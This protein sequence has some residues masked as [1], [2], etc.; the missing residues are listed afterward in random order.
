MTNPCP[1]GNTETYSNC[2][3]LFH[4]GVQHAQTAEQLMRSRYCAFHQGANGIK[5][6]SNYLVTTHHPNQ[7]QDGELDDLQ[8]TFKHQQWL[9]LKIINTENGQGNDNTGKV[10]FVAFFHT[11][12]ATDQASQLHECSN[13][14]KE[15]NHWFYVDGEMLPD[16]KLKRNELCWCGSTKKLKLCHVK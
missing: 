11:D 12:N 10:E 14:I 1:C 2:C 8:Q 9:S 4:N 3:Q 16:I 5:G 13:F 7:R 15:D 6:M